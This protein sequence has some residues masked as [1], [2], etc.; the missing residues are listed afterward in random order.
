MKWLGAGI[1]GGVWKVH[2]DDGK[3]VYALKLFWN[4]F[5][6]RRHLVYHWP[7]M[8]EARSVALLEKVLWALEHNSDSFIVNEYPKSKSEML[9]NLQQFSEDYQ[10][11]NQTQTFEEPVEMSSGA[12]INRCYGW[13]RIRKDQ[14]PQDFGIT[15]KYAKPYFYKNTD[16]YYALVYEY[17]SPARDQE[18][19]LSITETNLQF[20]R[21]AGFTIPRKWDNWLQGRLVDFGDLT[22]PLEYF[23]KVRGLLPVR[24]HANNFYPPGTKVKPLEFQKSYTGNLAS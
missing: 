12:S 7:I 18:I 20:F 6:S 24:Y 8:R 21:R 15:L 9:Q 2:F 5:G 17:V 14:L 13:M 19:D 3:R 4:S 1:E 23:E 11:K 22:S 10:N 16:Y